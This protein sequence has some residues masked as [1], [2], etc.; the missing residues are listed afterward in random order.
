MKYDWA[1]EDGYLQL[2]KSIEHFKSFAQVSPNPFNT[3]VVCHM[4]QCDL[5]NRHSSHRRAM[6][7][8][9]ATLSSFIADGH[10]TVYP[11]DGIA[12]LTT[13]RE[14]TGTNWLLSALDLLQKLELLHETG[15]D[16][17]DN[18]FP[19]LFKNIETYD[20]YPDDSSEVATK[21]D[22]STTWYFHRKLLDLPCIIKTKALVQDAAVVIVV[23]F[24][25]YVK[26]ADLQFCLCPLADAGFKDSCDIIEKMGCKPKKTCLRA[27]GFSSKEPL[28]SFVSHE[29]VRLLPLI[30]SL[31]KH[32]SRELSV[33]PLLNGARLHEAA[34]M[35]VP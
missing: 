22:F 30:D 4:Q 5:L 23:K 17:D 16:N 3:N 8:V 18:N 1:H 31:L 14:N 34:T 35:K 7:Q 12:A 32:H 15:D 33:A 27:E 11:S 20:V 10:I 21:T 29:C 9:C 28:K 25:E 24:A 19:E 26:S 6:K 2:L 13:W